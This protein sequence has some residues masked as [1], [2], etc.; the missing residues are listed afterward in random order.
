MHYE[1]RY[2]ER[3]VFLDDE[4]ALQTMQKNG[5]FEII[6][7]ENEI[8]FGDSNRFKKLELGVVDVLNSGEESE[9]KKVVRSVLRVSI[10]SAEYYLNRKGEMYVKV[11]HNKRKGGRVGAIAGGQHRAFKKEIDIFL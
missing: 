7:Y 5:D 3:T 8:D 2:Q 11:N 9:M 6:P 4:N 1:W 10:K